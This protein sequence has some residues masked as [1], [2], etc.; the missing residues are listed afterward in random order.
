MGKD[1]D[2]DELAEAV[3]HAEEYR[4]EAYEEKRRHSPYADYC[5]NQHDFI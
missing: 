1:K 2:Y 5:W 3:E 4:R